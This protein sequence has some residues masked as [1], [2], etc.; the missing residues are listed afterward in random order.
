VTVDKPADRGRELDAGTVHIHRNEQTQDGKAR[1]RETT[2]SRIVDFIEANEPRLIVFN[3][4]VNEEGTEV[5][6]VQ[7]HPD[8]DSFELH[9]GVVRERAARAY[10]ETLERTTSIHV[11]GTPTGTILEMLRRSAGDGV[12]YTLKQH[13]LGGFTRSAADTHR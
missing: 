10:D 2:R 3:E 11:F 7:V 4:Y 13:H 6:V 12:Q 9:M 1:R 5:G 8:T